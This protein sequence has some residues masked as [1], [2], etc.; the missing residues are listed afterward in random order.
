MLQPGLIPFQLRQPAADEPHIEQ[1]AAIHIQ[2]QD[3][4][5]LPFEKRK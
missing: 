5:F 3:S 4:G 1:L 2:P